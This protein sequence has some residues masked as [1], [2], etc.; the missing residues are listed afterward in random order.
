MWH[1]YSLLFSD[2]RREFID[3]FLNIE[4]ID[5]LSTLGDEIMDILGIQILGALFAL[6]MIYITYMHQKRKE[7]TIK[8]SVF[9]LSAWIC[10]LALVFFPTFLDGFIKEFLNFSR[11]LDFY[12]VVG[13]MFLIGITFHTYTIVRK[14]QNRVD[15]LVRKIA[16]EKKK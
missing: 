14:N 1:L 11:R 6:V 4:R 16:I 10:F 15:K 7:F 5:L 12:I 2:K 9:W 8:E 3:K 13:F